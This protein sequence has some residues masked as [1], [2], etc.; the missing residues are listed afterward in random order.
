MGRA[1]MHSPYFAYC[2][3]LKFTHFVSGS[4]VAAVI[5]RANTLQC[6]RTGRA[7]NNLTE[8]LGISQLLCILNINELLEHFPNPFFFYGAFMIIHA[9]GYVHGT[10][11]AFQT[12]LTV[13]RDNFFFQPHLDLYILS[14]HLVR[15]YIHA[16]IKAPF[17]HLIISSIV[18]EE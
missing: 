5:I 13:T 9:S 7:C 15:F 17:Q 11:T 3:W 1:L 18:M 10:N 8:M 14:S 6:E 12:N 4:S 16:E 2:Q